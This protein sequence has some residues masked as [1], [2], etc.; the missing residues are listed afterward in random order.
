[1]PSLYEQFNPMPFDATCS[2]EV[3]LA[4]ATEGARVRGWQG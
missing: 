2:M 3:A 4:S 1:M